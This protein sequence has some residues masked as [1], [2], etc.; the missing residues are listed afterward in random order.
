MHK[1]LRRALSFAKTWS[2]HTFPGDSQLGRHVLAHC[3][4]RPPRA[5]MWTGLPP[6]QRS[7]FNRPKFCTSTVAATFNNR[8]MVRAHRRPASSTHK[9]GLCFFWPIFS[10]P[11]SPHIPRP[12]LNIRQ[13]FSAVDTTQ[14]PCGHEFT[15]DAR[16]Q[17]VPPNEQNQ[18]RKPA[19]H[20][21]SRLCARSRAIRSAAS[22][23]RGRREILPSSCILSL[24]PLLLK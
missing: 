10:K 13:K 5:R 16:Q 2:R 14:V 19:R 12:V 8:C 6:Q 23:V 20:P 9:M 4:R 1:L 17:S 11:L 21:A 24:L 22:K 18:D 15:G 3:F 7:R